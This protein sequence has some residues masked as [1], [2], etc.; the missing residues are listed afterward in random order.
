MRKLLISCCAVAASICHVGAKADGAP[1]TPL[2]IQDNAG[3][4][5]L[6]SV[7]IM[8]VVGLVYACFV[9]AV[10]PRDA[11]CLVIKPDGSVEAI[12]VKLQA[13]QST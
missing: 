6:A 8:G 5:V 3:H 11:H 2:F 4:V 1:Q 12:R 10:A 13:E 7:R 9:E